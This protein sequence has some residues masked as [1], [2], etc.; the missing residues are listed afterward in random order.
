MRILNR[1][2]IHQRPSRHTAASRQLRRSKRSTCHFRSRSSSMVDF[3]FHS[4]FIII[5]IIVLSTLHRK[6][7]MAWFRRSVLDHIA[8]PQQFRRVLRRRLDAHIAASLVDGQHRSRLLCVVQQHRGSRR[9]KTDQD[10]HH[11]R[12]D[13][14]FRRIVEFLRSDSRDHNPS[15]AIRLRPQLHQQKFRTVCSIFCVDGK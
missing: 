12:R 10:P 2:H 1:R 8:S 5:R 9:H 15:R 7:R 6:I 4:I 14:R 13:R 11:R 3:I